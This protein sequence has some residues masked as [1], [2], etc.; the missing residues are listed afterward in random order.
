MIRLYPMARATSLLGGWPVVFDLTKI[1]YLTSVFPSFPPVVRDL[2]T[3]RRRLRRKNFGVRPA[4][5]IG[6]QIPHCRVLNSTARYYDVDQRN[7]LRSP[8]QMA[9]PPWNIA[10]GAITVSPEKDPVGTFSASRVED[11]SAV[12]ICALSQDSDF[13]ADGL[14]AL[15][16]ISARGVSPHVISLGIQGATTYDEAFDSDYFWRRYSLRRAFSGDPSNIQVIVRPTRT[17][18]SLVG[19]VDVYAP[20]L[21]RIDPLQ[22]TDEEILSDLKDKLSSDDWIV[23]FSLDGGLIWRTMLLEEHE[24]IRL[25]EKWIGW[26]IVFN[27]VGAD[28]VRKAPPTLDGV[29]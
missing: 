29:W 1:S 10:N 17:T 24:K 20:D 14:T 15:F 19:A 18:A 8:T 22:G 13:R 7:L 28:L 25:E 26:S 4:A 12:A 16:S 21:R 5:S 2:E 3:V 23:D 6:F 9:F 11:S 27:V